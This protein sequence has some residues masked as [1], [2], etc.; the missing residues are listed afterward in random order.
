M[1][2]HSGVLAVL[3]AFVVIPPSHAGT[4]L[5]CGAGED[6]CPAG[7]N[8][9][10]AQ[11]EGDLESLLQSP[12]KSN[13]DKRI[14]SDETGHASSKVNDTSM[15]PEFLCA[16]AGL[17][18]ECNA[19]REHVV[20]TP[21]LDLNTITNCT[22]TSSEKCPIA[23]MMRDRPNAVFPGGN[24][25]CI[26]STSGPFSFEV[27]PGNTDS[28]LFYLQGGGAC[29][30]AFAKD[31]GLCTASATD[32]Y[33]SVHDGLFDRS[34]PKNPFKDYTVVMV[35][36]CAGDGFAGNAI[37]DFKDTKSWDIFSPGKPVEQKG[38]YNLKSAMEWAKT[39]LPG[40]LRNLVMSG[41]SAGSMGLQIWSRKLLTE[42]S[43]EN[44]GVLYD[45]YAGIF[46]EGT[47]GTVVKDYF[48]VC[49]GTD[50]LEG[51]MLEDCKEGTITVQDVVDDTIG[52]FPNVAF[53]HINA[54]ADLVQRAF[55]D[56]I[57]YSMKNQRFKVDFAIIGAN[58]FYKQM[59][60]AFKRYNR[61][62]NWLQFIVDG[63]FHCFTNMNLTYVTTAASLDGSKE[64]DYSPTLLDFITQFPVQ[65]G[66]SVSSVCV[67]DLKDEADW[68]GTD[69]CDES[70]AGKVFSAALHPLP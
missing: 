17:T 21:Q 25:R 43:Y 26:Y 50:L 3:F 29:W 2:C 46:P 36:Y 51:K 16:V 9:P 11:K 49:D 34:N 38:Y 69:Y 44:A 30:D 42:F 39:N 5:E 62:P 47:Q 32:G 40:T 37:R 59:S 56:M 18:D 28:L 24:T 8:I 48:N 22:M 4:G 27:I 53:A 52:K 6:A 45:S 1:V 14:T 70:T 20:G 58:E 60:T 66:N 67:G 54:R 7:S 65:K 15:Q 23:E 63:Q 31:V 35:P 12:L 33:V 68:T 64:D 41:C 19:I 13:K 57:H 55:W 10:E 61:H